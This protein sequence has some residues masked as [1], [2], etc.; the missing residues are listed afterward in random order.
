[1]REIETRS[2][3]FGEW[4]LDAEE[5]F[6]WF[7]QQPVDLPPKAVEVL[8]VLLE[9]NGEVVTKT[10]IL[11]SVWK[12]AFVEESNLAHNI[13]VLRKVF[14]ERGENYIHTVPRRGYRFTGEAR[15]VLREFEELTFERRSVTSLSIEEIHDSTPDRAVQPRPGFKVRAAFAAL[16]VIAVLAVGGFTVWFS[17]ASAEEAGTSK[18]GSLAVLPLAD[19]D[20]TDGDAEISLGLADSLISS[21]GRLNRFPVRP[22]GGIEKYGKD[23]TDAL[24]A[25]RELGVDSVLEG[26]VLRADD[27]LRVSLRL[28][29]VES[30]RQIWSGYFDSENGDLLA[31]QHTISHNV[32][33]AILRDL[34]QKE[35]R[36]LERKP[37]E[38]SEA[39]ALYLAGRERW[40]KRDW[41]AD[42]LRY[43][44][45]AI[46]I[47][48]D[49]ALAHLGIADQAAIS[50]QTDEAEK[51]LNKALELDP[52]LHEAHAT[53]G[54][55][56]MFLKWDWRGAEA[57]FRKAVE[58]AP[59]SPKAH[60]WYG[61]FLSVAGRF[62]E[63][64]RELE[65]ASQLDPTAMIIKTDIAEVHYFKKDY[66]RA[67]QMLDAVLEADPSFMKARECLMRV[68]HKKGSSYARELI[69]FYIDDAKR[70][71][72]EGVKGSVSTDE[73]EA[74]LASGD[75][76][77]MSERLVSNFKGK[78][79]SPP[80]HYAL[81]AIYT[82]LGRKREAVEALNGAL[83][84][85]SFMLPFAA[86]DPLFEGIRGEP[87][88]RDVLAKIGLPSG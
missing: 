87:G 51:A 16:L 53:R 70:M 22:F 54:F 76:K 21:L 15:G 48:P 43:Y 3:E 56:R 60:H 30:G 14:R 34:D 66:R 84:A 42:S 19:P 45:K 75:E 59:N 33:R 4:R 49:F 6:L 7:R 86:V 29:E 58:L 65:T 71:S 57:S 50:G 40:L 8:R 20:R 68:R 23:G 61:T 38:S 32:A 64:L 81:A 80:N 24:A 18:I 83:R 62:D 27:R 46:E 78:P 55:I 37:T 67:E 17:G 85:R 12:D 10:E 74:L 79:G 73:L 88:F 47:D 36:S 44:R 25:G 1:M 72:E 31:L 13:Y 41:D 39:Y 63:A 11:D 2:Y 82:D 77:K 26:T 9:K 5:R 69:S 52:E 35:L 28:L